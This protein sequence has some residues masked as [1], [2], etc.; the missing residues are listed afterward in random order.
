MK[1]K[2]TVVLPCLMGYGQ[3]EVRREGKG[4]GRGGRGEGAEGR[5]MEE[6]KKV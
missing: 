5:Q 3:E 1:N 2:Y 4:A 6:V